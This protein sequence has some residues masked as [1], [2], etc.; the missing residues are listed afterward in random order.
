MFRIDSW[1]QAASRASAAKKSQ[2]F[3]CP[4]AQ[5]MRLMRD[6]PPSILP[7]FS[8]MERPLRCGFG[9]PI[10]AQSRSLPMFR[11]H[12]P[13]SMMLGISSLPPASTKRTL[14]FAFSAKRRATTEPD[15]PEPSPS[16]C[17][18]SRVPPLRSP[19]RKQ[20]V[21]RRSAEV[22]SCHGQGN[23]S[24][25]GGLVRGQEQDCRRLLL[26][27]AEALHQAGGKGLI[28]DLL[29]PDLLLIDRRGGVA[30]YAPRRR[31]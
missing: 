17:R 27:R 11:G 3:L 16:G 12:W 1:L 20:S 10:K 23:A 18:S 30:R 24:D 14:T 28:H 26:R 31:L 2:S 15:A 25:V 6:P 21:R 7:I 29:V 8:G 4:R 22:A 13:A 19:G 9:W 5:A